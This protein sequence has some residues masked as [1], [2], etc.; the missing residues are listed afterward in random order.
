MEADLLLAMAHHGL[1]F[2]LVAILAMEIA[3]VRPG[4]SAAGLP[5]LS[6]VDAAYGAVAVALIAVGVCRVI[7]GA[8]G[9]DY[10]APYSVFWAKMAAFAAVGLLS[11]PPTIAI[12][13]WRR[14]AGTGVATVP[15]PQIR[16]VRTYLFAEAAFLVAVPLLAA[17]M[18]RGAFY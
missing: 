16:A 1:A 4:L 5:F 10:Y 17:M 8:K 6:R 18:A 2:L 9:W 14:A 15:E 13:R 12:L 7:Y 3:L 11:I